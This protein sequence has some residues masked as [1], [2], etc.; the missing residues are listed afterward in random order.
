MSN[1]EVISHKP[2]N[3]IASVKQVFKK[4][5]IYSVNYTCLSKNA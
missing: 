3:P 1:F 5:D 2:Y 4:G